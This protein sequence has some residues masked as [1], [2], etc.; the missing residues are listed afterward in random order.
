MII[1][2]PAVHYKST[3]ESGYQKF[4]EYYMISLCN[5]TEDDSLI[6]TELPYYALRDDI[7]KSK[8]LFLS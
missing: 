8:C 2:S 1:V 3:R 4:E 7:S 6:V 5:L